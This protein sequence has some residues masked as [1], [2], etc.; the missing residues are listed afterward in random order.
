[1]TANRWC[2]GIL[3]VLITV[4][5]FAGMAAGLYPMTA[6]WVS[7]YNQS[8]I[9]DDYAAAVDAADPSVVEQLAQAQAYNDALSSGDVLL[10]RNGNQPVSD[11][12][13]A[14]EEF[15][16]PDLL[17][18]GDDGLMARI[19]IP[20]IGVDLPIYHGTSDDVLARGAGH[21]EGSHL[22]IGGENTR[23]VVTAHRG[24]ANAAMFT[25][26]DQV[27][28]GDLFT[29]V[30]FDEVLTY[31]VT[32]TEVIAPED[33]S[34]LRPVIGKDLVT[35]ITCTPL[36]INTHRILVTGERITP[37]PIA[38]VRAASA[39]SDVP[40][41][42]WWMVWSV[43]GAGIISAYLVIQ[44]FADAR[45]TARLSARK[46]E[47]AEVEGHDLEKKD[48]S[49]LPPSDHDRSLARA[50]TSGV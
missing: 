3:T 30:V 2:P 23:A 38:E 40:G 46:K 15:D 25:N 34:T 44:G 16:Y 42:P 36:G 20:K 32:K 14:G 21:L 7:S 11:G 37:T 1:M 24:L 12:A 4:I 49:D 18:A 39:P 5:A 27:K 29:V 22:P 6:Q 9:V 35:L 47:E 33:T 48:G 17:S 19:R 8:L 43:V 26:L 41:F 13:R 28:E 10:E 45:R 50:A 31:R